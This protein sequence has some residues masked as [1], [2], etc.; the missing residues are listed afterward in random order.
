MTGSARIL[1]AALPSYRLGEV[2]GQG[3]Y[4]VVRFGR[5]RNL[6]RPVAVKQIPEPLVSDPAVRARFAEEAQTL[7]SFD[8]PHIR[9]DL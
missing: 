1:E 5:H 2:I 7:A 3:G 9:P 6:D 8:H 4:G